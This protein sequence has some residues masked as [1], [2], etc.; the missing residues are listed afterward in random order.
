MINI[1]VTSMAKFTME[2]RNVREAVVH[3][4]GNLQETQEQKI[5]NW[6]DRYWEK[7]TRRI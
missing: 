1:M 7:E 6:I 2:E 5:N 4:M 3:T